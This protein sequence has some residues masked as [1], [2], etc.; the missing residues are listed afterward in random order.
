MVFELS[1]HCESGKNAILMG[2]E[3]TEV[4]SSFKKSWNTGR[5]CDELQGV[6]AKQRTT[7]TR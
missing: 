2:G 1:T 7:T 6:N 3:L 5:D 4:E